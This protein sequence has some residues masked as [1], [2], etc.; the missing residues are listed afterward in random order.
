VRT[1]DESQGDRVHGCALQREEVLERRPE[2]VPL[3][4]DQKQTRAA[5]RGHDQRHSACVER[6]HK[7]QQPAQHRLWPQQRQFDEQV[8]VDQPHDPAVP[9]AIGRAGVI[10]PST[11]GWL[12]GQIVAFEK[13]DERLD[14]G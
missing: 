7:R 1:F 8:I 14:V 2:R 11:L 3:A 4:R 10:A 6:R 5:G 13:P 12:D 9:H